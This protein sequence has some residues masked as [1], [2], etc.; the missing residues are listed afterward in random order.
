MIACM[1]GIAAANLILPSESV[2]DW[3]IVYWGEAI[4]LIAFGVA[5]FVS[6]KALSIVADEGKRLKLWQS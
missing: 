5:W 1:V 2:A 6:G 3:R 4:A